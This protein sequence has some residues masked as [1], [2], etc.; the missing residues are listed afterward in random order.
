MKSK[1]KFFGL[2]VILMYCLSPLVAADLNDTNCSEVIGQD[3]DT[4]SDETKNIDIINETKETTEDSMPDDDVAN[5][6]VNVD[7]CSYGNDVQI[8]ID[9]NYEHPMTVSFA[10]YNAAGYPIFTAHDIDISSSADTVIPSKILFYHGDYTLKVVFD[11]E[12][13][14]SVKTIPIHI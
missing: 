8:H 3:M 14:T 7:P 1:L 9:T 6:N 10:L 2:L 4:I 12:N 5:F 13:S 11:C